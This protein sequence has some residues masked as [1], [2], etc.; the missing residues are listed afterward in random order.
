MSTY[1]YTF[2]NPIRLKDAEG[3]E[4]ITAVIE[5]ITAFSISAGVD[6]ISSWLIEGNDYQTAFRSIAWGAA[7]VDGLTTCALS[8]VVSGTGSAK[9]L[10]KIANSKAGRFT[11]DIVQTM[12]YNV[13]SKFEKGQ[14]ESFSDLNLQEEFMFASFQTLLSKG[15]GKR[16]DELLESL[17]GKN[18][19]LYNRM[20]KYKRNE[21]LG[22]N[23]ARLKSDKHK[24]EVAKGESAKTTAKY[25]SES[26][27]AKGTAGVST[28]AVKG[29]KNEI[30]KRKNK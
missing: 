17:K 16:A 6:F 21:S 1:S 7:A 22:K 14:I 9:T 13:I 15:L 10:A 11:I 3:E 27:K 19:T 25:V 24:V 8:F 28:S 29:V 26:A 4:P 23:D 30:D 18:A 20:A 2:N 12:T 5:G